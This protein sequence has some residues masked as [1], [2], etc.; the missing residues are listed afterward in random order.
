VTGSIWVTIR[1][2]LPSGAAARAL[3]SIPIAVALGT[4][5]LIED[6]NPDFAILG[7]DPLVVAS[8]VLLIAAFGPA[9]VLTEGAFERGMPRVGERPGVTLV[10]TAVAAI[11][12]IL[13][14]FLVLPTYVG[15]PLRVAGLA[16]VFVGGATLASWVIRMRGRP[17]PAPLTWLA[18]GALVVATVAGFVFMVPEIRGAL[19]A[20]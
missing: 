6:R 5:A 13:T 3:V 11:G 17:I 2:W 12:T 15:S 4:R 16:M 20:S 8:L 7:H 14:M 1:P 18:R 9:M 10:Y 19:G